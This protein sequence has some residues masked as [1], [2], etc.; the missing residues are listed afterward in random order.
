[1]RLDPNPMPDTVRKVLF[2][3]F[4]RNHLSRRDIDTRGRVSGAE[5][6]HAGVL[7]RQRGEDVLLEEEVRVGGRAGFGVVVRVRGRDDEGAADVRGVAAVMG[8]DVD[9]DDGCV[10]EGLVA[11]G[12]AAM[13]QGGVLVEED[14]VEEEEPGRERRTLWMVITWF[15]VR[16]GTRQGRMCRTASTVPVLTAR[17]REISAGDF[18]S[19]TAETLGVRP[20]VCMPVEE[21][22]RTM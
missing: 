17:R 13:G 12:F 10:C 21:R 16:P 19:R 14:D 18:C 3:A 7:S 22:P 5:L 1:M 20:T 4:R 15:S 8:A 9:E 6:L 11:G 2:P